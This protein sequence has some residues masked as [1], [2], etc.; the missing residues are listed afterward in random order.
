MAPAS[1]HVRPG[2]FCLLHPVLGLK[3]FGQVSLQ[4]T[5][6]CCTDCQS[7]S[8]SHAAPPL[9]CCVLCLRCLQVKWP[10]KL[11]QL[12]AGGVSALVHCT[13]H[14]L[15]VTAILERCAGNAGK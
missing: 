6:G 5:G 13:V 4:L 12:V 2:I 15:A 7:V 10:S 1:Q 9:S 14:P 8:V 3:R 11:Q